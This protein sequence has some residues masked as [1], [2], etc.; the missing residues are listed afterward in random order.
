[1]AYFRA[2]RVDELVAW[3]LEKGYAEETSGYGHVSAEELAAALVDAFDVL[4][5]A[6][7]PI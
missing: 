3:L 7:T 2:M 5:Y 1:M 4:G 6:S